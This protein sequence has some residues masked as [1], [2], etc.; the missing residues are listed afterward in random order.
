MRQELSKPLVEELASYMREQRSK[1][2]R[3]HDLAKAID[4]ILKRWAAFHPVPRRWT[5]M[6]IEQCR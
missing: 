2:S 5:R 3:G 1:L 4:Y 6:S